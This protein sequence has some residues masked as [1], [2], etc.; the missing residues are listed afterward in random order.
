MFLLHVNLKCLL[1]F[2][3]PVAFG[4]FERFARV[5]RRR[6]AAVLLQ[7]FL[8]TF[9]LSLVF[10]LHKWWKTGACEDAIAHVVRQRS[11]LT[12]S[13]IDL[14]SVRMQWTADLR[15]L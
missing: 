11:Q 13:A 2:V 1:V 4:T 5:A 8:L 15:V 12:V 14:P 6:Y 7:S 9:L 3:M 10:Y